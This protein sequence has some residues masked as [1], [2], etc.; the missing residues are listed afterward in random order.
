MRDILAKQYLEKMSCHIP[1]SERE[2]SSFL[3]LALPKGIR[4]V[5]QTVRSRSSIFQM[6]QFRFIFAKPFLRRNNAMLRGSPVGKN[7]R[8]FS[9]FSQTQIG[10]HCPGLGR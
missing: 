1:S 8:N 5:H 10:L 3:G 4:V 6:F 9:H 7:R 2:R